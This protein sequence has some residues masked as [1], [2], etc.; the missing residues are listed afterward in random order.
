MCDTSVYFACMFDNYLWKSYVYL[1]TFSNVKC[2]ISGF[3][4][5][6]KSVEDQLS[7]FTESKHL[8]SLLE[9]IQVSQRT[10]LVPG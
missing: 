9:E 4:C 3:M 2:Q 5:N 10:K 6:N 1:T 8:C 7:I